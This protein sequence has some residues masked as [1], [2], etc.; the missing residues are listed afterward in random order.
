M[1]QI[2]AGL[3]QECHETFFGKALSGFAVCAV[4]GLIGLA[5]HANLISCISNQGIT[6]RLILTGHLVH[7]Q[8]ES[9][10]WREVPDS[11]TGV[12]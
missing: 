1:I 7:K 10:E 6:A 3:S 4:A 11:A 9:L 8:A 5:P 2:I 12:L